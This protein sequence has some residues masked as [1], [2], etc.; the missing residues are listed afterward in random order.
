[1][2]PVLVRLAL[3]AAGVSVLGVAVQANAA[4]PSPTKLVITDPAGDALGSQGP[5]DITNVSI[6]TTGNKVGK[7]YTAKTLVVSMTVVGGFS[8]Y[9]GATY[10]VDVDVSGCGYANFTY[11]P[12]SALGEGGLFTECGSPED[13]TGS[14]ATLYSTPPEVKGSTVTWT[15]PFSALSSEFKAKKLTISEVSAFTT[16]NEP[17]FGIVGPG[18]VG[19]NVDDA[20]TDK[21]YKIG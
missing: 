2:R 9:P 12:G 4:V 8:K 17:V 14:T 16:Q 15:F 20:T 19:L 18:I 10:E 5:Y 21:S 11:T 13:E 6:S 7:T 1:M 3:A